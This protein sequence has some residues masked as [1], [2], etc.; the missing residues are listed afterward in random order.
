MNNCNVLTHSNFILNHRWSLTDF[1]QVKN[2]VAILLVLNSQ[3]R[4]SHFTD[5]EQVKNLVVILLYHSKIM[6]PPLLRKE[7]ESCKKPAE[8]FQ[9]RTLQR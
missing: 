9:H 8:K 7:F 6:S 4:S 2:L 3:K 5:F 1:K